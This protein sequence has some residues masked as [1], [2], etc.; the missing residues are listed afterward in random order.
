M[1]LSFFSSLCPLVRKHADF[2]KAEEVFFLSPFETMHL[3]QHRNVK[4][5]GRSQIELVSYTFNKS[6]NEKFKFTMVKVCCIR[7]LS[8]K[9]SHL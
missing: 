3:F 2:F 4:Q 8:I 6:L 5:R 1:Q 7:F 9:T